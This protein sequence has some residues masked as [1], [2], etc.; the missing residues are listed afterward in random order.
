[1]NKNSEIISR[2]KNGELI[3]NGLNAHIGKKYRPDTP[4]DKAIVPYLVMLINAVVDAAFFINLFKMISYDSP[5]LLCIQV[6]G[7]LFAFDVVPVFVGIQ[8]KR[9]KQ[10]ICKDKFILYLAFGVCA[11]ACLLNVFLRIATIDLIAP[12]AS[13][14]TS[15][16]G[17]VAADTT[18]TKISSVA[19]A[20]TAVGIVVPLTGSVGSFFISYITYNPLRVKER[21]L[22]ELIGSKRD[23]IRR[24]N[25]DISEY[26]AGISFAEDLC[27][28][29]DGK[30]F[31]TYKYDKALVIGYVD[32][33]RD[34]LKE[35]LKNPASTNEL[36]AETCSKILAHLNKEIAALDSSLIE[37]PTE[38]NESPQK[39]K[40]ATNSD[41]VAA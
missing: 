39:D 9:I 11:I 33:V 10:K 40:K 2:T 23:E 29:D 16:F 37:P 27:R 20:L 36:S 14:A 24:F 41:Y 22:E 13:A 6:T 18:T 31:E 15:Y 21:I 30:F 1:M 19:I 4:M 12:D 35:H 7:F 34:R 32:Y 8:L 38:K 5:F 28:D 17:S 26:D 25:A 3:Y